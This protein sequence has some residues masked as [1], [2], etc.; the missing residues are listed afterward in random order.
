[1]LQA[2]AGAG[3]LKRRR[4]HDKGYWI[5][6]WSLNIRASLAV[7]VKKGSFYIAH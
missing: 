4:F 5:C 6:A 3:R 7:A 1:M 2:L